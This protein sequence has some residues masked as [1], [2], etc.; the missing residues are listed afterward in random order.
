MI[1]VEIFEIDDVF[2]MIV[3]VILY[4]SVGCI[5]TQTGYIEN[6]KYWIISLSLSSA[7][8]QILYQM[9][10]QFFPAPVRGYGMGNVLT[11]AIT[12][13]ILF[14]IYKICG[15]NDMEETAFSNKIFLVMTPAAFVIILAISYMTY[16]E[17]ELDYGRRRQITLTILL[18]AI[19]GI[20]VAVI[21]VLHILQQREM[22]RRQVDLEN[23]YNQQQKAYFDLM[24]KKEEETKR[25]RHDIVNHLICL[26]DY[27]KNRRY[28]AVETYLAD[29]LKEMNRIRETQYD[30]GN[31]VVN[32]L[33]NY[34]FIPIKNRCTLS[35]DGYLGE[36]N[37]VSRMDLCTIF[38]NVFKN[39]AEAVEDGGNIKITIVR[40]EKFAQI[41]IGNSFDRTIQ[42]TQE[43]GLLTTKVDQENHGFGM[44]NVHRAIQ[45]NHGEFQY[46]VDENWFEVEITL[47][48]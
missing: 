26:Q 6:I 48:V 7:V 23:K 40:K 38:S 16:V 2:Q 5:F 36:W 43:G 4:Y 45:K 25:F 44:E 33:L 22:L 29:I 46:H 18:L 27:V 39:A 21:I 9:V 35:L 24:L 8:E 17:E 47:P 1:I 31:E 32:V 37:Q 13:T 34:Y 19:V 42:M 11:C 12:V 14:L 41:M 10:S 15:G 28:E 20:C 3:I 30:V